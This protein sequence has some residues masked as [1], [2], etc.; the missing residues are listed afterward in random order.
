MTTSREEKLAYSRGYN[1]ANRANW[2][3]YS[4]PAPDDATI[5]K[6]VDALTSLCSAA[7]TACATLWRKERDDQ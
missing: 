7:D 3:I 6:L 1:A 4:P 5:K 2:P